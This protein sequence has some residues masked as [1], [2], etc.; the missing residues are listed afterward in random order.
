MIINRTFVC[1]DIHGNLNALKEVLEKSNFNNKQDKI[2]FLGDYCDRGL[3]TAE[4]VQF[5]IEL[6]NENSNHVFI[7]GN[8]DEWLKD[9]LVTGERNQVWTMQGGQETINS[10]LQNPKYLIDKEHEKF[11]LDLKPYYIDTQNRVFVHG[12]FTSHRGIG[13]E[14][15]ES[16]YWWDR[17]LWELAYATRKTPTPKKFLHHKEIYIGHNSTLNWTIDAITNPMGEVIQGNILCTTPMN[18]HNVW[19]VDT[20]ASYEK[21]KLTLLNIDTKEYYQSNEIK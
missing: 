7:K 12:G 9:Y 8:H 16:N 1:G 3:Q 18:A 15:Y 2:I 5:L 21:G 4:L 6:K 19:N 17:T 13:Y 14:P 11:F 10:Y 20:G